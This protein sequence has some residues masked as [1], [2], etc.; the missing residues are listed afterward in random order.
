MGLAYNVYLNSDRIFGCKTCKAHLA[1]FEAIISRVCVLEPFSPHT[2]CQTC[3]LYALLALMLFYPSPAVADSFTLQ[4]FRGQHGKA[5]LFAHV[6]NIQQ[7][8]A[9]ERNMTTG[10]HVVRDIRCR[11]C[12]ETVGWKYDKAFE[13]SEK[14]KEGKF[15]LEA[16]LLCMVQ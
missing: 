10:R 7:D 2:I 16:E 11:Q 9:V 8:E 12:R 13:S 3:R 14:Y 4:N 15:I 6:V 5:Y 1:T